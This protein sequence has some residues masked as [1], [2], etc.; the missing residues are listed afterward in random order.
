[1]NF[2]KTAG[3]KIISL[4]LITYLLTSCIKNNIDSTGTDSSS[5]AQLAEDELGVDAAIDDTWDDMNGFLDGGGFRSAASLPCSATDSVV[6]TGDT[7]SHYLKFNGINCTGT[8]FRSGQVIMKHT[9]Q[10]H[11]GEQGARIFVTLKNYKMTR[12]ST[13]KSVTLN[14]HITYE[15]TSGGRLSE[16]GNGNITQVIQKGTG[17]ISVSFDNNVSQSWSMARQRAFN[18][19][20][21]SRIVYTSGLGSQ[22]G[23][24]YLVFWGSN[25]SGNP[26]NSQINSILNYK[27]ACSGY[28]C[29]GTKMLQMSGALNNIVTYGYDDN[30][31]AVAGSACPTKIKLEIQ[32]ITYSGTIYIKL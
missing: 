25:R 1:M 30:N 6:T 18:G 32:S 14:G 16:I 5:L 29:S 17:T 9:N 20:K 27:E 4:A 22:G 26:F 23:I 12:L 8:R 28:P 21:G 13:T 19:P 7:I 10:Q 31:Q 24:N 3:L 2:L 15:N 11:W